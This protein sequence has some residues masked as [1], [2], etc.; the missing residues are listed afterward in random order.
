MPKSE[1]AQSLDRVQKSLFLG[2]KPRNFKVRGRTFNRLSG[3]G[4]TQVINVQMGSFDPPGTT[5][6]PGLRENLYGRFTVNLGVY[7]PEVAADRRVQ[8][9]K[10]WVQVPVCC[11]RT[12]LGH[13]GNEASDLWWSI[14][15]EIA[16]VE[17]LLPRIRHDAMFF[18]ARY[19]S[20]DLI[21]SELNGRSEAVGAG[22]TPPRIVCAI[23]LATRGDLTAARQLL[24]DQARETRN[25]GHPAY[26]RG[27]AARL[28]LGT[29]D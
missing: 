11:I 21:L 14:H 26:V 7:V 1:L 13:L 19:E 25:P 10:S 17:D 15:P 2:L 29:I 3:D 24:S 18:F 6:H 28:G 22:S 4:L 8:P 5:Y 12:R 16:V 23:I 20:R 27:L 9:T